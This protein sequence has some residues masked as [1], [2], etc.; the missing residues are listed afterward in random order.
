MQSLEHIVL[1]KKK[2]DFITNSKN[3]IMLTNLLLQSIP[4]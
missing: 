3:L 2:Y 4:H 1:A